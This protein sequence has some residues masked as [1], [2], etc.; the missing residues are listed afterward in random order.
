MKNTLAQGNPLYGS[1]ILGVP[2]K[3]ALYLQK[4]DNFCTS[5]DKVFSIKKNDTKINEFG[6]V[7]IIICPFLE[8]Q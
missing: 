7:I 2:E 4:G 6:E 1:A 8:I 5:V 3:K